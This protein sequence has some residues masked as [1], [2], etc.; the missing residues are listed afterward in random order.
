MKT[1]VHAVLRNGIWMYIKYSSAHVK[2][3]FSYSAHCLGEIFTPK[4]YSHI[5]VFIKCHICIQKWFCWWILQKLCYICINKYKLC[6]C[7]RYLSLSA[8]VAPSSRQLPMLKASSLGVA[9]NLVFRQTTKE[10]I[11]SAI[12]TDRQRAD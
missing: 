1:D 8:D 3:W 4:K 11:L 12:H 2:Q 10:F 6:K 7:S 5:V 9:L